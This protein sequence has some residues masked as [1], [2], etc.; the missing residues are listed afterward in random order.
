MGQCRRNIFLMSEL[1]KSIV[2]KKEKN[3]INIRLH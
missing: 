3:I 2:F 1:Y